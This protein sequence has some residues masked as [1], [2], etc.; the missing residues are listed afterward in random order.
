MSPVASV[1]CSYP[2]LLL[3]FSLQNTECFLD[4]L[5]FMRIVFIWYRS[6]SIFS[7]FAV[8]GFFACMHMAKQR[9][10][11]SISVLLW[12]DWEMSVTAMGKV[13]NQTVCRGGFN[14]RQGEKEWEDRLSFTQ[15]ANSQ[16]FPEES[17]ESLILLFSLLHLYMT[18]TADVLNGAIGG[19]RGTFLST[20]VQHIRLH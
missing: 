11:L 3:S 17:V 5:I 1:A 10:T 6:S 20:V 16:T 7:F 8:L 9:Y 4:C 2:P 14:N 13:E 12:W 18:I 15:R 19:T